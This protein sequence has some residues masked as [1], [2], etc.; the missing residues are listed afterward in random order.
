MILHRTNRSHTGNVFAILYTPSGPWQ[1]TLMEMVA[2]RLS[3]S[4]YPANIY[5]IRMS[6]R[7]Y[8]CFCG[9]QFHTTETSFPEHLNYSLIFPSVLQSPS[10]DNPFE[11]L[12]WITR[13][14]NTDFI[15]RQRTPYDKDVYYTEGFLQVQTAIYL[16]FRRMSYSSLDRDGK[17]TYHD[18]KVGLKQMPSPIRAETIEWKKKSAT[19][20]EFMIFYCYLLPAFFL[21]HV[22]FPVHI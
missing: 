13:E 17:Y 2:N 16:S 18:L 10:P 19:W 20:V 11:D 5:E 6:L 3:M 12:H 15:H 22:S 7:R 1:N 4:T 14:S 9:V 21:T 8:S